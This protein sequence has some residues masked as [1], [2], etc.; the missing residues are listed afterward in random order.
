MPDTT[1]EDPASGR[2]RATPGPPAPRW[3]RL[4]WVVLLALAVLVLIALVT[5]LGGA[6]GPARHQLQ[7]PV[8]DASNSREVSR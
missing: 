5:G 3:V 1:D 6:H 8:P 7:A 2:R 4:T